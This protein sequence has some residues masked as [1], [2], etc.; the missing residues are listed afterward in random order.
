MVYGRSE[1]ARGA[2]AA[3]P[4]M[5]TGITNKTFRGLMAGLRTAPTA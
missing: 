2:T 3:M 1:P 4:F 5:V